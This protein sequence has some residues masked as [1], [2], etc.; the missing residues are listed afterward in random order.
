MVPR[1]QQIRVRALDRHGK[2]MEIN[3]TDFPSRVIQ[4]ESDHLDGVLFVDRMRSLQS[5]TFM[6]EFSRYHARR[7]E[8]D[9]EDDE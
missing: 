8:D 5:L 2:R 3:A 6:D 9:E 4:H 7:N 1:A